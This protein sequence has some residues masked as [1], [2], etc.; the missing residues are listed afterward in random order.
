MVE[1]HR[2]ASKGRCYDMEIH[3]VIVF[4]VEL[5]DHDDRIVRQMSMCSINRQL[6]TA[7]E[8]FEYPNIIPKMVF[9]Q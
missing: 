9:C 4:S 3:Q 7:C 1:M 2:K 8:P 5:E 6:R